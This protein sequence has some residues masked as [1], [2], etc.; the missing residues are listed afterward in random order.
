MIILKS[1]RITNLNYGRMEQQRRKE[2]QLKK[3]TK[4]APKD[5]VNEWKTQAHMEKEKNY[6]GELERIIEKEREEEQEKILI[7]N[8]MIASLARLPNKSGIA[9]PNQYINC[10]EP[11]WILKPIGMRERENERE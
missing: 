5:R 9:Y 11:V 6:G 7:Q 8:T 3:S 4:K 1:K 10:T 2:Q